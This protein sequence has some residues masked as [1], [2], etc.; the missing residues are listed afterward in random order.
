[1][2]ENKQQGNLMDFLVDSK[3]HIKSIEQYTS[4]E[5]QELTDTYNY[6]VKP[7]YRIQL[8]GWVKHLLINATNDKEFNLPHYIIP[9]FQSSNGRNKV[10]YL[11]SNREYDL[12]VSNK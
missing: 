8:N 4:E 6:L 1:M 7:K 2:K 5:I 10:F 11:V 12:K 3:P 9:P